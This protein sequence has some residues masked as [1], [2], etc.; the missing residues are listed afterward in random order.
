MVIN[1]STDYA[2][3]WQSRGLSDGKL[4]AR[5]TTTSNDEAPILKYKN[6]KLGLQFTRDILRQ[7][8][9]TFN[10]AKVVNIYIV[11]K[12]S[13]HTNNNDLA[14]KDF[15]FGAVKVTKNSDVDK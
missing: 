2:H 15:L 1:G 8:K 9:V 3:Y 11:Y 6:N 14:L 10:H 13:S 4:N 12:L 7:T 5:E